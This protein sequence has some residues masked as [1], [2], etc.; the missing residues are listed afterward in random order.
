MVTDHCSLVYLSSQENLSPRQ[1]CWW[2]FLSR[3]NFCI[4]YVKGSL[5]IVA[6]ALSRKFEG[7]PAA[8]TSPLEEYLS[9]DRKLDPDGDELPGTAPAGGSR[10]FSVVSA[11][12]GQI[13]TVSTPLLEAPLESR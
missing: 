10:E 6:D 13:A 1:V 7:L 8:H 5:N 9:I 3:F 4:T 2:E 12:T 11:P